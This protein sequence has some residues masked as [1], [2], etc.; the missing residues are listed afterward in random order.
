MKP[1][2]AIVVWLSIPCLAMADPP[3]WAPRSVP[4]AGKTA[5]AGKPLWYRAH[6][7]VAPSLVDPSPDPK[8]LWRESMT[9]A[10]QDIPG[11][12][13]VFLNGRLIVESVDAGPDAPTRF[14]VP[15]DILRKEVFNTLAIRLDGAAAEKGLVHPPVFGGYL[16]EVRLD[17]EWLSASGEITDDDLLPVAQPPA[18]AAY[19]SKDWRPASTVLQAPADPIRGR[20]VSPAD[21]LAHLKPAADLS[22]ESLLH[23]PQ[24]AQPT[25]VSFDARGR[26]WISQYRQ[27][28]YPA[29]LKMISRDAYYRGKY[30]RVPPPPPGHT[31]GADIV[32][33]HEDT[34]HDGVYDRHKNVLTGLNM[35]NSVLHGHGGI[36]V[37]HA[38][39]LLFYPDANGDDIPDR[40]PE[41]RLA[42]FG[43]EDTHSTANGLTWGPDGWLYGAQGSTVTSH[44]T[45]PGVPEKPV[46]LEG[47]AV[48]RHHPVTKD[49]EIFADG[50]GNTFGLHF[51]A[52]GRLFSGHNGGDTRGWHHIQDGIYLKQGTSPDKFGPPVNPYAF[53]ELPPMAAS[54]PI[55]RFTHNIIMMEGTALPEKWR[56]LL[57]GTDPLHRKL[58]ASRR[59]A[60]GSTFSTTDVDPALTSDDVTFRPVYLTPSPDG[61]IT[62]ADFREE[63]IAHGQ[64]YQGQIDPFTGRIYRLR[65]KDLPLEHDTDLSKKSDGELI[66][67]LSHPNL[68]HRQTAVRLLSERKAK[69][70][71]DLLSSSGGGTHPALEI[72]WVLHQTGRLDESHTLQ[73]LRH[74]AAMVRAWAIRLSG[75][76]KLLPAAVHQAVIGLAANEPDAEVRS[77]ILSTARRL[78]K[79]QALPLAAA[80]L[81]RDMDAKDP[82]IPLM[83]WF[84][85]ESHCASAP[86]DV[87]SLFEHQPDLWNRAIVRRHITPRLMRRFAAT[88]TR[89]D[90][91][92][93]ARLLSLA[94]SP[95]DKSALMDG[96][97]QAFQGRMLPDLP[98]ELSAEL[99][100][101]GKG[102]LLLRLRQGDASALKEAT[103]L[104]SSTTAPAVERLQMARIFGE[105][106]H[107]PAVTVLL[108]I[109]KDPASPADLANTCLSSLVFYDEPGIGPEIVRI[110]PGVSRDRRDAAFALLASRPASALALLNAVESSAIPR[111]AITADLL[112]R[113]RLHRNDALQAKLVALFPPAA[114]AARESF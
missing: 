16:D 32:S 73:A 91:L 15:K 45:R 71:A 97:G 95:A 103:D 34:D 111:E 38:P 39:Y 109:A 47:C 42:G 46:Y 101:L 105:I 35:A 87:I 112:A 2:A 28:P 85:L 48:W 21:A 31:P 13:R 68:W 56:G 76:A 82:F 65:G 57:L 3:A 17:R 92:H 4:S 52:E 24:V 96:F 41:V 62:I 20:Q 60:T 69:L 79:E 11:P 110:L 89:G 98:P 88:G 12:F 108:T 14:K 7:Q 8:D 51:D 70:T 50:S 99:A 78:P 81:A 27:Y 58:T 83:A 1:S 5:V 44:I 22:V 113:L 93:A 30:D 100:G 43:L 114:P 102:S 49:F 26:M 54:H 23:E 67:L 107:P 72:L 33:V 63:Y 37:M 40:D 29:G 25:H 86:G 104:L 55:A 90:L 74:P 36:W 106:H 66:A 9:F 6:L 53:G 80:V 61:S 77:Q 64:N 94:P 75:D 10:V 19:T 59:L 84:I 18:V